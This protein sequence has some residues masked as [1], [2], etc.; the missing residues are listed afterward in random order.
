M[1]YKSEPQEQKSSL[2]VVTPLGTLIRE[3]NSKMANSHYM[4]LDH[5]EPFTT[6]FALYITHALLV[7]IS[8]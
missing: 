8:R 3:I 5:L 2:I 6:V 7:P 4:I 1:S